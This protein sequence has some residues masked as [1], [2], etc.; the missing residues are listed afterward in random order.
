MDKTVFWAPP[1]YVVRQYGRINNVQRNEFLF[2]Y[3]L[4][5]SLF[6]SLANQELSE[7][8]KKKRT[9]PAFGRI[10]SLD[11]MAI[12]HNFMK[13]TLSQILGFLV[14]MAFAPEV[15]IDRLPVVLNQ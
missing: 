15:T 6:P 13:E 4:S 5:G 1:Q 11:K 9:K 14:R 3:V 7:G 2:R 10:S 8:M 12:E